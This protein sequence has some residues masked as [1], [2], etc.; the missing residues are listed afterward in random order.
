MNPPST[1]IQLNDDYDHL[2]DEIEY[3]LESELMPQPD[4]SSPDYV[5]YQQLKALYNSAFASPCSCST[6]NDKSCCSISRTSSICPHGGNY[7]QEGTNGDLVLNPNRPVHDL[8]YECHSECGCP[9]HC[10]NRLLQL[11]PRTGLAIVP[12]HTLGANQLGL[13]SRTPLGIGTFVCEYAGEVVTASE[14]QRRHRHLEPGGMNYIVCLIERSTGA[15]GSVHRTFIDPARR[16]NIG[17]YSNHSCAPNCEIISVRVD[18]PVP[19]L[20]KE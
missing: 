17:R 6:D 4:T 3:I 14:A 9:E 15:D 12:S 19:R 1:F 13:V 18:S 2:T 5:A 16:G 10:G 7:I 11:G 20:G 8:I